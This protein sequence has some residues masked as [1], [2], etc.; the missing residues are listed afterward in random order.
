MVLS[1]SA[2]HPTL[3]QQLRNRDR[4]ALDY[5]YEKYASPLYGSILNWV[6]DSEMAAGILQETFV[7]FFKQCEG[8]L[9]DE[10][11]VFVCLYKICRTIAFQ[12]MSNSVWSIKNK[13]L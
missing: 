9:N 4:D 10:L 6:D 5:I 8:G 2:N 11:N 12:Q 13:K 3:I 7:R 1:T